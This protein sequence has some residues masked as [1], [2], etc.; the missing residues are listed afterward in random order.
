MAVSRRA[1]EFFCVNIYSAR[2]RG[3]KLTTRQEQ[4][5]FLPHRGLE[6]SFV[7]YPFAVAF[8]F[9]AL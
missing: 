2:T 9:I 1:R 8:Q 3:Y 4:N 5:T 6:P 7:R